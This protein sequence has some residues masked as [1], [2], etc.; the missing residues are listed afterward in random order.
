MPL[1]K[2]LLAFTAITS[3]FFG[4]RVALAEDAPPA[5]PERGAAFCKEN[6]GK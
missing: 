2:T 5:P 6:P 4:M 3:P 1:H